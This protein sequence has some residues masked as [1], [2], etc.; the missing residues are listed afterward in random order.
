MDNKKTI[1]NLLIYLGIP[2]LLI[3]IVSIFFSM[4]PKEEKPTSEIIYLFKDM[5]VKEYTEDTDWITV[6]LWGLGYLEGLGSY[7]MGDDG[8]TLLDFDNK[9]KMSF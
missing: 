1:R 9:L 5:T 3:I 2:I 8:L 4:Q 6:D 7:T